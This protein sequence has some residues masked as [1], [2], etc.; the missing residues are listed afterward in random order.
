MGFEMS[1]NGNKHSLKFNKV[2]ESCEITCICDGEELLVHLNVK[3][4][5][6]Y[7]INFEETIQAEVLP[8]DVI[9]LYCRVTSLKLDT[10]VT[11]Y[12][13]R[14]EISDDDIKGGKYR[15]TNDYENGIVSIY[16]HPI[17]N[18]IGKFTCEFVSPMSTFDARINYVITEEVMKS[19]HAQHEHHNQQSVEM[20]LEKSTYKKIIKKKVMFVD[21][22]KP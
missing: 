21:E 18:A 4:K 16:V 14:K 6:D 8:G 13:D 19:I 22:G 12:H 15:V 3:Q 1:S 5:Q 20:N 9:R 2:D 7:L 17:D 11:W 10:W